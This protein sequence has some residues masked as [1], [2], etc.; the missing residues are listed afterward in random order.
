MT[1]YERAFSIVIGHEGGYTAN[2]NDPGNWTGGACG[3][4]YCLGTKYG[5]SAASYPSRDIAKLTLD[6]ARAIYK[7][8]YWDR[9]GGD[10][11]PPRLALLVFDAAVNNGTSRAATW[12]QAAVGAAQDGRV[13]PATLAKA[14]AADPIAACAEFLALR[15]HFMAGLTTWRTFGLGWARRLARLPFDTETMEA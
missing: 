7:R 6:D 14:R 8:D 11:L 13:G 10:A 9:I 1:P 2:P 4:G 15:L 3:K 5:V 12:L